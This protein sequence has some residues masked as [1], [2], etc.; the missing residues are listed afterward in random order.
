[1]WDYDGFVAKA[2]LYFARAQ[3]HP[4][5]EDAVLAHWLLLG[6]EYLLRAPLAKI[7]PVLLA[8]PTGDSIMAAAGYLTKPSAQVKSIQI[9]TVIERLS[10]IIP[11]FRE[12][13][14][15]V[16]YLTG[17]RNE[18][19]HSSDSPYERDVEQWLP[20]F[21]R[22]LKV[23]CE[24]LSI[25]PADMVGEAIVE[26]GQA[27]VDE[28]S[29]QLQ[30][31]ISRRLTA[32]KAFWDGLTDE[33]LKIRQGQAAA[34]TTLPHLHSDGSTIQPV[35]CPA[36]DETIPLNIR[37]VRTTHERLE[38]DCLVRD[39]V[40]VATGMSCPVCSLALNEPAEVR[41]AGIPQQYIREEREPLEDR[42]VDYGEPDYGND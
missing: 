21:T 12:R 20:H 28:A 15:D 40:Y 35:R 26:Q 22:V 18:E 19:M 29:R 36:C 25:D 11:D 10:V 32:A 1:M 33:E 31:E 6:L 41:A 37:P 13:Q 5:A 17:M 14:K 27:L 8:D 4:T 3:A 7:N 39:V 42:Y 23:V 2:R 24:H 16:Q 9:K 34:S 38:D 30:N